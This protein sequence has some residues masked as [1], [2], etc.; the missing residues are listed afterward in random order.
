MPTTWVVSIAFTDSSWLTCLLRRLLSR[1]G[2][3]AQV[4]APDLGQH[5]V[6]QRDIGAGHVELRAGLRGRVAVVLYADPGEPLGPRLREQPFNPYLVE[7]RLH[8]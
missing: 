2:Y 1:H 3:Q 4:Q 7:E 8:G 5:A 6:H